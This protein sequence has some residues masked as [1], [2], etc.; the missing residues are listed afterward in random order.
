MVRRSRAHPRLLSLV[1]D[2]GWRLAAD[3]RPGGPTSW[4]WCFGEE[5]IG[6]GRCTAQFWF[7]QWEENNAPYSVSIACEAARNAPCGIP[8]GYFTVSGND[9]GVY[10]PNPHLL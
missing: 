5:L 2:R 10:F 9:G 4:G 7:N 3:R 6:S 1:D 8:P